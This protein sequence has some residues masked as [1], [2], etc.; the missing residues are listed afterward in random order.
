MP[1]L[2]P[3]PPLALSMFVASMPLTRSALFV[4]RAPLT[5]GLSDCDPSSACAP[6]FGGEVQPLARAVGQRRA[7]AGLGDD[8]VRVVARGRRQLRQLLVRERHRSGRRRGDQRL[9]RRGDVDALAETLDLQADRHRGGDARRHGDGLSTRPEARQRERQFV[10]TGGE[11]CNA[12]HTRWCGLRDDQLGVT[13]DTARLDG[14]ARQRTAALV[15]HRPLDR[16]ADWAN[17]DA[18]ATSENSSVSATTIN[19]FFMPASKERSE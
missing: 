17:S 15:E 6:G 9:V 1:M 13:V 7:D 5:L 18:A 14:H 2:L 4:G 12:V 3:R 10:L 16:A 11:R 8:D 19:L